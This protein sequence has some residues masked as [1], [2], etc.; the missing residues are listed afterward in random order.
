MR[1]LFVSWEN[2]CIFGSTHRLVTANAILEG[3]G[4]HAYVRG[5]TPLQVGAEKYKI[6]NAPENFAKAVYKM[7]DANAELVEVDASRVSAEFVQYRNIIQNR[8]Y[9]FNVW[10]SYVAGTMARTHRYKWDEF[11]TMATIELEKCDPKTDSYTPVFEEYAR[12]LG[13]ECSIVYKELKL[14]TETDTLTRFRITAL[15]EKWKRKINQVTNKEQNFN[16]ITQ[17]RQEFWTNSFI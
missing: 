5:I 3:V 7:T 6:I 13:Q 1:Y 14:R 11:H 9:L 8:L 4:S 16:L 15:A 2:Y 17:M 12:T 10:E